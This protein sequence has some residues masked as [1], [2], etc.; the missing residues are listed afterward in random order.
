MGHHSLI[1]EFEMI[2]LDH[3]SSQ[4]IKTFIWVEL[5]YVKTILFCSLQCSGH[6]EIQIISIKR[7]ILFLAR[8]NGQKNEGHVRAFLRSMYRDKPYH[9][10]NDN[11]HL[12]AFCR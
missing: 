3:F 5:V 6:F 9:N 2:K 8:L 1:P 12:Q 4:L 10:W 7:H 11:L